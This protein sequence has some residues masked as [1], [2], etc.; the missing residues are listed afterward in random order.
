[1]AAM[2]IYLNCE[3]F[4]RQRRFVEARLQDAV[5][6]RQCESLFTG[7]CRLRITLQLPRAIGRSGG[8]GVDTYA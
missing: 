5:Q 6:K 7:T 4:S 2:L 1:M 3:E 8:R